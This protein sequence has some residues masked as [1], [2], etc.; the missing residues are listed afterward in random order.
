MRNELVR[1][2]KISGLNHHRN[3]GDMALI[4]LVRIGFSRIMVIRIVVM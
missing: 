2:D 1:T 3:N 4:T